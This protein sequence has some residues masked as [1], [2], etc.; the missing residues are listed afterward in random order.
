M[1]I[2]RNLIILS[3][4]D[5][6]KKFIMMNITFPI[7]T[8]FM[9]QM[10]RKKY[11]FISLRSQFKMVPLRFHPYENALNLN[12]KLLWGLKSSDPAVADTILRN[13]D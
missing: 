7:T 1:A 13:L 5:N 8:I 10:F 12:P 11:L 6:G 9:E 2:L 4:K 3:C